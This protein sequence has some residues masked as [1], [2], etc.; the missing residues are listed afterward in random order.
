[1]RKSEQGVPAY[2]DLSSHIVYVERLIENRL[3]G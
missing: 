3:E 2:L 1:M